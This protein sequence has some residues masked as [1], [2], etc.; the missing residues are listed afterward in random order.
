MY[1][2]Q[3]QQYVQE[4]LNATHVARSAAGPLHHRH[5]KNAQ[6]ASARR[7]LVDYQRRTTSP[8]PRCWRRRGASRTP[9]RVA[10][11]GKYARKFARGARPGCAPAVSAQTKPAMRLLTK[12]TEQTQIALGVRA[13]SRHDER[14]FA[15]RLLNAVL[16]ENMSSRLFQTV[17]EDHGLAYSIY[18]GNS[19]FDDAGDIVISAGL[20]LANLEKTLK[21]IVREMKRL[22]A[23]TGAGGRIPAR[24]RLSHRPA[25]SE[26]GKQREPNDVGRR[27]M[28]GL[29]QNLSIRDE[30]KK[31]LSEVTPG[32][33]C[34][35]PRGNFSG[36]TDSTWRSISPLKSA[37]RTGENSGGLTCMRPILHRL[38]TRA[39]A[40][41]ARGAIGRRT[42][43]GVAAQC[44]FRF[45]AGALL[46]CR[47]PSAADLSL[48]S[49]R[50]ANWTGPGRRGSA[51]RGTRWRS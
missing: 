20:D 28:A 48:A 33:T 15:L 25:R 1:M 17:R 14:R 12:K 45:A 2:D 47:G 32:A 4:L 42:R 41:I 39:H 10:A 24:A 6:R 22:A 44:L 8:R 7:Q 29:R 46:V 37:R 13:C 26:F 36:P 40:G 3:P 19:F 49:A 50:A 5:R 16:G 31:R 23:A 30:V 35:P 51:I 43:G 9:R 18:S 27:T 38:P 21:L 11:A 34:A